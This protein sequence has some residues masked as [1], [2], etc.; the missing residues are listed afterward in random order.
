MKKKVKS[1]QKVRAELTAYAK[2]I[3]ALEDLEQLFQKW[4]T[5]IALAPADER[6]DMA[7][8]AILEVQSLLD[9][10]PFDGLTINDEVVIK[11]SEEKHDQIVVPVAV[12]K[13][14]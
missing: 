11:P 10:H 1:E 12:K 5:A 3:G 6:I 8:M 2:T 13:K 7:R 4:D 9:I 14:V